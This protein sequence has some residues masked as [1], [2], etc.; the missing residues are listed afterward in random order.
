MHPVS[1]TASPALRRDSAFLRLWAG[2]TASQFGE[3]AL[4]VVLPLVAVVSLH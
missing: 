1:R 2:Q 3:Q 4:L